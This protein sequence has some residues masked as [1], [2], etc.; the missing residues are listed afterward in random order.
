MNE[1]QI[2]PIPV[3]GFVIE[4]A[5]MPIHPSEEICPLGK[6][7]KGQQ[8]YQHCA[9]HVPSHTPSHSHLMLTSFLVCSWFCRHSLI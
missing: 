5:N 3:I 4:A 7:H 2:L 6:S 8:Q 1:G 9:L